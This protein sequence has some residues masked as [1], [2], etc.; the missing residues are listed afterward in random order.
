MSLVAA[1]RVLE[2]QFIL[3]LEDR[4]TLGSDRTLTGAEKT[5]GGKGGVRGHSGETGSERTLEGKEE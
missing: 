5:L 4:G 3:H 1:T 2:Y